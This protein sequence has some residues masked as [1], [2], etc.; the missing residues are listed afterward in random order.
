MDI[1]CLRVEAMHLDQVYCEVV[2]LT[3]HLIG[4]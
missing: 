2:R 1:F 3:N 4:S